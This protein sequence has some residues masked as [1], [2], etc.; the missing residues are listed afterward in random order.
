LTTSL[1]RVHSIRVVSRGRMLEL[2]RASGNSNDTSSSGFVNAAR[3]AGATEM[4]DGTVYARAGGHLRLDLRRVDLA[5]GAIGDVHTVEGSDLFTLVDSGT[6]R[7]VGAL[8]LTAPTGSVADVT[9]RSVTAYRMYEQGVRAYYRGDVKTALRFF[10]GALAEDSL[11]ALAW[12]YS[13][14]SDGVRDSYLV[15]MERARRLS[16][17]A[18]DLERLTILAG[19]AGTV[20]SP[21][22]RAIAETLATRYPNQVEGHLWLGIARVFD[23]DFM[24]GAKSLERAIQIDSMALSGKRARC[25]ACDALQ[26]LVSAYMLADSM[27]AAIREAKR[28]RRL[29]PQSA[30]SAGALV[31]VLEVAGHAAEADSVFLATTTPDV[32]YMRTADFRSNHFIRLGE[33]ASA[34][35]VL[36]EQLREKDPAQQT[37][38]LWNLTN[39]YREQGRLVEAL[40]RAQSARAP[41]AKT[42]GDKGPPPI[43]VLE[44]QV[45]LE[46]GRWTASAA[47]F[48][49]LA[50]AHNPGDTPS[51]IARGTVWML[52]QVAGA[53]AGAGDTLALIRL[54]DSTRTLGDESGYGRD[55]RLHHYVR[56]LLLSARHDD[57]AAI[58]EFRSAIYSPNVGFTRINYELARVY[59]RANRPRDAVA[60]LQPALRG[61]MEAS[62]LYL[63]RTE[64]HELLGQAW[65]AAGVRDSAVAHYSWVAKAWSAADPA[66]APRVQAVRARLAAFGVH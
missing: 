20:S 34:D 28:W 33:Y 23:G 24:V 26:W 54:A 29:Q 12:Y 58:S 6:A 2:M 52:A 53:R 37:S 4:I 5:S 10:D 47:L 35:R 41:M 14:M 65:E 13:A 45:L 61:A 3:H 60:A 25:E 7:L 19:W 22:L 18:T 27:P 57:A 39:S 1:A 46:L 32:P 64:I 15:R 62:N 31:H 48:D 42:L 44:A 17:R 11:F 49:S 50:N 56:G 51:Q 16:V 59:L 9:T 8:G 66:L 43:N 55:R 21:N 63:N 36:L 38:A 30:L 40:K